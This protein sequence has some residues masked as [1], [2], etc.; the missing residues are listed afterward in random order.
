MS[1]KEQPQWFKDFIAKGQ[2]GNSQKPG[3]A[4]DA[5]T[6][7][8]AG[9]VDGV[10]DPLIVGFKRLA[11]GTADASS[12][13]DLV[14]GLGK[15]IPIIGGVIDKVGD[16]GNAAIAVNTQ[17]N[18][19]SESGVSYRNNLGQFMESAL[20]ARMS[21]DGWEKMLAKSSQ[22][23]TTF[24]AT[25]GQGAINFGLAAKQMQEM[26]AGTQLRE[27]GV[28]AEHLN[29]VLL[30]SASSRTKL[31]LA[32]KNSRDQAVASALDLATQ[33]DS[34]A[35]ITGKNKEALMKEQKDQL[36]RADV[37]AALLGMTKEQQKSYEEVKKGL[38]GAGKGVNDL[39][40]EMVTGG[41]RSEKGRAMAASVGSENAA[42]MQRIAMAMK[43]ANPEE[44]ERL[45][46]EL[47]LVN[48]K[49]AEYQA[50][51]TGRAQAQYAKGS[52]GSTAQENLMERLEYVKQVKDLKDAGKSDVEILA[53]LKKRPAN[54]QA[55]IKPDSKDGK[56]DEG[57]KLGR[58]IN[59]VDQAIGGMS[60][61]LGG[62]FK[63]A[64]DEVGTMSGEMNKLNGELK[65]YAANPNKFSGNIDEL[66]AKVKGKDTSKELSSAEAKGVTSGGVITKVPARASGSPGWGSFLSG[67]AG[68]DSV[69]EDF[70]KAS[71]AMLHGKETVAKPEQLMALVQKVKQQAESQIS[72]VT[73]NV[74][75]MPGMNQA[76]KAT[77][78]FAGIGSNGGE[79]TNMFKEMFDR[80][81]S[82]LETL[83]ANSSD[84]LN[85]AD[86]QIKVTKSSAS[87]N[88]IG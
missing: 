19:L 79:V 43:T 13:V 74:P 4:T 27:M 51:D 45:K 71:P 87:G 30:L 75:N 2:G 59:N 60:A 1:D 55:G 50:S 63:K 15:N 69:F 84:M 9:K 65:S 85:K 18:R 58:T 68:L 28:S 36:A 32:D 56:M 67:G 76:A 7:T 78:G 80:L 20:G 66:M 38:V 35:K 42:E 23:L 29:D 31:D 25:A 70:G 10:I 5:I 77:E 34:V 53:E 16:F 64:G 49:I 81:N 37:Q 82:T 11:T 3:S 52:L 88:R 48:V 73:K 39:F 61:A 46:K 6:G 54:E 33:M 57:S 22:Q 26:P 17:L 24:G 47:E 83:A 12:A 41:V 72:Q 21:L 62:H 86:R 8:I 40:S 44:Q 14:K